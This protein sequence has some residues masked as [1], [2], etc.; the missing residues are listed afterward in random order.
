LAEA[1]DGIFAFLPGPRNSQQVGAKTT[2]PKR[3]R[4]FTRRYPTYPQVIRRRFNSFS[5][6]LAA[7]KWAVA[8][9]A[10]TSLAVANPNSTPDF[11]KFAMIR[12]ILKLA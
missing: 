2:G 8:G 10:G 6:R 7:I 9:A 3:R 1:I 4:L 12:L 11:Q 5:A